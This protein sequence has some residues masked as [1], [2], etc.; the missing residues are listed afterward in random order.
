MHPPCCPL[1]LSRARAHKV[2]LEMRPVLLQ[3]ADVLIDDDTHAAC[4]RNLSQRLLLH[5]Q[6]DTVPG[7]ALDEVRQPAPN[8]SFL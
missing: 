8:S 5:Q 6:R 2:S 1:G 7:S 3:A 4:A